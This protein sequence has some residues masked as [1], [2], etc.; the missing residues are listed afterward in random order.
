MVLGDVGRVLVIGLLVGVAGAAAATRLVAS[1]LYGLEPGEPVVL[2]GAAGV[3]MVV[4]LGAGLVPAWR[5]ARMDPTLALR[6][7]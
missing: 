4:A 7:E 3:L 1:F 6:E 5:A 2:A